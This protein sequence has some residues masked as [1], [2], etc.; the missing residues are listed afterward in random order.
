MLPKVL[1]TTGGLA[2]VQNNLEV[3]STFGNGR[4]GGRLLEQR[5]DTNL[6]PPVFHDTERSRCTDLKAA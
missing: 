2:G 3:D 4:R 1:A 5:V 6:S